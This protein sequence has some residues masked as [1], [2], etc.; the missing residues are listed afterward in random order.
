L[1]FDTGSEAASNH[2]RRYCCEPNVSSTE[3][4]E[5]F[6]LLNYMKKECSLFIPKEKYIDKL[7]SFAISS[8]KGYFIPLGVLKSG[9]YTLNLHTKENIR[10]RVEIISSQFDI[11]LD[12]SVCPSDKEKVFDFEIDE[13]ESYF[14]RIRSKKP[15]NLNSF[16]IKKESAE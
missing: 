13:S 5:F 15:L 14:L 12:Q 16:K 3:I 4:K 10:F 2:I 7:S 8:K 9:R 11:Y 6:T 1:S